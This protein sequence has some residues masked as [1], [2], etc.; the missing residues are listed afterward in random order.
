MATIDE[1]IMKDAVRDVIIRFFLAADEGRVDDLGA[2]C[3]EDVILTIQIPAA[4][5]I[6][7]CLPGG[8]RRQR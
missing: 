3:A 6:S 2:L 7:R 4:G 8:R 1:L 5:R